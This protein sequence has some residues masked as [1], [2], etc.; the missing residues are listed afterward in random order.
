MSSAGPFQVKD[1]DPV[2][3]SSMYA[4]LLARTLAESEQAQPDPSPE[5]ARAEYLRRR[6]G[7]GPVEWRASGPRWVDS[8]LADQVAYDAALIRYARSLGL[9]CD[10]ERFGRPHDER[11][12]IEQQVESRAA[13]NK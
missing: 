6:R 8:A 7:S 2:S 10:A 13:L 3:T 12:R 1:T 5:Q 4:D 9:N 11:S